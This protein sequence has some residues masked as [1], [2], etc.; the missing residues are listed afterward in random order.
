MSTSSK[1]ALGNKSASNT[2]GSDSD[3][4]PLL[5][6]R[7]T[8]S[9]PDRAAGTRASVPSTSTTSPLPPTHSVGFTL[10]LVLASLLATTLL[11]SF[12]VT[13]SATFGYP[14]PN[15]RK[16]LPR[17][18]ELVLTTEE[19][20]AYDGSVPGRPIYIAINGE[21]FDVSVS[22]QYYGT[23][24]G[25][26]GS[27]NFFAGKDAARAY[28]TGCFKTDLTHDLRGLND[29]QIRS[30]QTWS[31]FYAKSDKYFRVG[32]VVHEPIDPDSPPP[33]PCDQ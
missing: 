32:R 8:A 25:K 7:P 22:P 10:L 24:D 15:W 9:R 12:I 18:K 3:T 29:A 23:V 1:N 6:K 16:Y 33:A 11:T 30:L 13:N 5:R 26:A 19:L 21:V 31:D 2:D 14:V 27:Y 20:K 17:G 28:I 4:A